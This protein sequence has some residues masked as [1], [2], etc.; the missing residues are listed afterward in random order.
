LAGV[1]KPLEAY[2]AKRDFTKTPEPAGGKA[3]TSA[4]NSYVIQKHAARR[5]H[6]DFRLELNG[7]LKSWAV[8][9]GPSLI[10]GKKR[11]AVHVEDHPLEYG[12]F[13]GVIPQGSYGAGT[14]MIWD[15]G[16]WTPEF[17]PELGYR[18]GHLRFQLAGE[19]LK[20]GWHLVRMARKPREKQ[21]AW[22]LFKSDDAAARGADAPDILAEMPRSAATG[23]DIDAIARDQDRTWLAGQGEVVKPKPKRKKPAVDAKAV[24]G[25]KPGKLPDFV[26]PCLPSSVDKAPSG[27]DWVHEIKHDGYRVQARIADGKVA[28]LTRQGLDW[29]ERF[30]AVARAMATLPVKAALIDGEIVAQT[31]AGIASFT[32]LVDVLK[33]GTGALVY[34][35]F[36]LLHLDGTD[37]RGAT[38]VDRKAALAKLLA[39]RDEDGT[40]LF[41]EHIAGDGE[42]IF[43]HAGRLGLEGIVSK[44]A[45][46][47]YRSGRV[48]TWLKVKSA[49]QGPFVVAGYIPS[50]VQK[51]AVGALVLAE[52]V[53][54]TLT[55]S[56]HVGSGFSA[57][58]AT[59]LWRRLDPMRRKTPPIVDDNAASKG[60]KWI[61]PTLVAEVEYRSRTGSGIIRHATFRELIDKDPAEVVRPGEPAPAPGPKRADKTPAAARL[62]NPGRLLWPE[63]GI[64]KQGLAE[65]YAEIAER[66]LPHIA[67]RPLSVVRCPGGVTEQCFFQKHR[68]A[69]LSNAVRLVP[70]PNE[71]EPMIAVDD[72]GGL[73][74]LV[75]ASVLEIHPWGAR[76]DRPALP[77]RV[78]I[79]L[80]PADDV[81][82]E[83]V[84]D[85]ALEVRKRLAALGLQSFVKTTGGKG[86]HVMFPIAPGPDWPTLKRFTQVIAERMAAD[87]PDRYTA[88]MAKTARRGRIFVD[89]LRNGMG[90]T[91][92]AAYSTR[93]RPGAA[94][95]TPLAWDEIGAV[96][97][98][99]FTLANL[100]KRLQ[101]LDRDPW[102]GFLALQQELPG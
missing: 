9:E 63:Q 79:D 2:K 8:P 10:P 101:F 86:L 84:V 68:W 11:L 50:S 6:Y 39:A 17:D 7:V 72:L 87:H 58:D 82:W 19:K 34:Y 70:V 102:E 40:L 52:H 77:D 56:G 30:P 71:R 73:L 80:D 31:E 18:K 4:G 55:A 89:Y 78:T 98:S 36:D 90:A 46:S 67:D 22:L 16:T 60:A 21:E 49:S 96:R 92:V 69:G 29:T 45:S 66:I 83:R 91:A 93:A 95:S 12:G 74:E 14:V 1:D 51:N 97:A 75:Q 33:S 62:T 53:G 37:L 28:L 47:P 38:L 94:V 54:G 57:A 100:P 64:T 44:K 35:A 85:A 13:E 24:A 27:S 61:E 20:G 99:H 76:A 32:A 59:E 65:F 81:P 23:R 25:A 3:G 5:L 42:T 26:E 43:R 15:K 41:S 48:T 88:N